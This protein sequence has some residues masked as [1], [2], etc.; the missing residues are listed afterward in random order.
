MCP[1]CDCCRGE[2]LLEHC[3]CQITQNVRF[4]VLTAAIMNMRA[5][6]DIALCSLGAVYSETIRGYISECSHLNTDCHH[7]YHVACKAYNTQWNVRAGRTSP[8]SRI[9][10]R[11]LGESFSQMTLWQ[12]N[13]SGKNAVTYFQLIILMA[14]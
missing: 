11:S 9:N 6:W 8:T 12:M 14:V 1:H 3:P 4:Q 7:T 13:R 2:G 10:S 5:S